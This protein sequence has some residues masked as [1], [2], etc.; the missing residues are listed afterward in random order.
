M[1]S[2]NNLEIKKDIVSEIEENIKSSQS[3][4]LFDYHGLSVDEMTELR[5]LLKN[6][7]SNL[8]IYKNTLTKLAFNN[9]NI[10]LNEHLLGPKAIAFG[11]DTISP[12][13]TLSDFAKKHEKLEIKIGLVDGN[14]TDKETL[15]KLASI[16]SRQGLLTMLAGSMIASIRDLSIALNMLREQKEN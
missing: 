8:K 3:V 13:K 4:I 16:P 14:I 5:K 9:L 10:D 2:I 7:S 6:N 1:P 12:I 15:K 11:T